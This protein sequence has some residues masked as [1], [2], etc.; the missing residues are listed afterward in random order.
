MSCTRI[1]L[2]NVDIPLSDHHVLV[3]CIISLY[4]RTHYIVLNRG[5][6]G[7]SMNERCEDMAFVFVRRYGILTS[8]NRMFGHEKVEVVTA[9]VC[10]T[11]NY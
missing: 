7:R 4:G 10:F 1:S 6:K 9:K 3:S 2:K 11:S 8:K 5:A